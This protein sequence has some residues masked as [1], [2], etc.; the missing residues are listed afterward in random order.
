MASLLSGVTGKLA[1]GAI[2]V[3][4]LAFFAQ[5]SLYNV[6]PGHRGIVFDRIRGVLPETKDEGTHFIV[7][8]M[9]TPVI[10]DVRLRP[11][12]ITSAGGC[13]T[14]DLQTVNIAMRVLTKPRVENLSVLYQ[15]LGEDYDERVIPS[16]G[17]EVLK[18]VVAQYEAAELLTKRDK[19]SMQI[20]E[21][22]AERASEFNII[23]EDVSLVH[24]AFSPE[25][26]R[27]IE[28]KQIAQQ[29]AERSRFVVLQSEQEKKAAIITAEGESESAQ[30]VSDALSKSGTGMIEIRRI[31][32]AKSIADS[33]ARSRNVTW[34]PNSSN[35]LLNMPSQ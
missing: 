2:A 22:L 6:D 33:L 21:A 10:Y 5:S 14:K 18:G 3:G 9:Q 8:F 7:P 20:K 23:L 29:D 1:G 35:M 19:V 32:A 4:S 27:A 16:I 17:N 11:K 15:K 24:L 26:A 13:Q 25:F 31:E 12:T 28:A 34:L 30:L